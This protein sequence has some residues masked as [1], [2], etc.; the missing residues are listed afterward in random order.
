[1]G[2]GDET[3]IRARRE[4]ALRCLDWIDCYGDGAGDG[5]QEYRTRSAKGYENMAGARVRND[6]LV[7]LPDSSA[8]TIRV[9]FVG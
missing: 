6:A 5:F 1:M 3:L 2:L 9:H 4:T 8:S 7:R